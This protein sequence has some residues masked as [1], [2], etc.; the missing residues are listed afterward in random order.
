MIT[1]VLAVSHRE[2]ARIAHWCGLESGHWRY[3]TPDTLHKLY[4][5]DRPVVMAAPCWPLLWRDEQEE[6]LRDQL[7][8]RRA[9]VR[10]VSCTGH[11]PEEMRAIGIDPTIGRRL[12]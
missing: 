10:E 6:G 5:C 3:L 2:A 9:E 12:P 7:L 11:T 8:S 1:F 4:G